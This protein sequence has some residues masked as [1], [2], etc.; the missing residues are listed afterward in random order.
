MLKGI[1]R[2][3]VVVDEKEVMPKTPS[4]KKEEKIGVLATASN[5]AVGSRAFNILYY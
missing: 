2:M 3:V 1:R 5:I 4:R